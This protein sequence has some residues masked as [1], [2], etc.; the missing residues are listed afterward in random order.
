MTVSLSTI[1]LSLALSFEIDCTL[2]Q[3]C[4]IT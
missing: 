1:T 3:I 4:V 2:G